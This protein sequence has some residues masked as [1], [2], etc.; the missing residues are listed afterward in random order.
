MKSITR[1]TVFISALLFVFAS[2]SIGYGPLD[3]AK[4]P[5]QKDFG[6]L[7]KIWISKPV[8]FNAL[9]KKYESNLKKYVSDADT[10]FGI[11][12]NKEIMQALKEGQEGRNLPTNRQVVQKGI[13]N[14][15]IMNFMAAAEQF[16]AD[17]GA[18]ENLEMLMEGAPVIFSMAG[19]RDKWLDKGAEF[20]NSFG[21]MMDAMKLSAE[22]KDVKTC[23]STAQQLIAFANKMILLSTL[24]ELDGF[25][26]ARGTDADKVAEKLTEA[27]Y[28]Y[29]DI[30]KEHA[31]RNAK[32]AQSVS[33][34][35]A[36][37]ADQVD[38]DFIQKVLSLDFKGELAGLDHSKLG[39]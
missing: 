9:A 29:A 17:K 31:K 27:R 33:E 26:K 20:K 30:K 4:T 11:T 25:E 12:L 7:M 15:F 28:Y 22:K 39:I 38:V 23:S 18:N 6:D 32:G 37:P 34:Q 14:A 13:Q 10:R 3:G 2:I 16:G 24:Y 21:A 1:L 8:D 5:A 35:L 36:K 19:R